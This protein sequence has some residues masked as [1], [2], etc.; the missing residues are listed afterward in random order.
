M[1]I[2]WNLDKEYIFYEEIEDSFTDLYKPYGVLIYSGIYSK[3]DISTAH[4]MGWFIIFLYQIIINF[5]D[6]EKS[7][8]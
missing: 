2:N 6:S 7:I 3:L 8:L 4:N 1:F 5:H